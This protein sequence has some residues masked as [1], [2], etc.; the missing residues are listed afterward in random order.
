MNT[1]INLIREIK[2]AFGAHR[3]DVNSIDIMPNHAALFI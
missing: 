2:T 3:K 1:K